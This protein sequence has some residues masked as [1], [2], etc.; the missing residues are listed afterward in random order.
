MRIVTWNCRRATR[1]S[2][3]WDYFR[4]LNPDIAVLQEV[5]SI[6]P[7]LAETYD[8]R[9]AHPV[10]RRGT[11]QKFGSAVLIRGAIADSIALSSVHSWVNEE[12]AHFAGNLLAFT[13]SVPNFGSFN[14]VNVYSPAWPV[15][16]ERLRD[17]D[18]TPVK[19]QQNSNVWVADLLW[20]ALQSMENVDT[21]SWIIAGD[22]NLSETFDAW[23]GGPR[24]NREYLDRMIASGLV[25][26]L[27]HSQQRLTPTFKS[28]KG[29][30]KDQ[31]DHLF[32]SQSLLPQLIHCETGDQDLV[33]TQSLSDHLPIIADFVNNAVD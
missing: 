5:M 19:L 8:V 13:V 32:I 28:P 30:I 33:F 27:R 1:K 31:I 26:C 21:D 24:G 2:R 6:A 18:V 9:F 20:S 7:D 25:E 10:S 12:L 29:V 23:R 4:N 3:L 15:S 11:P 22:F 17:I 14:V 16:S